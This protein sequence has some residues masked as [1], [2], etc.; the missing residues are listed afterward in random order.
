MEITP[1][2]KS[3]WAA[4]RPALVTMCKSGIPYEEVH[5]MLLTAYIDV[6]VQVNRGNISAAGRQIH[7]HRNT[8]YRYVDIK[9]TRHKHPR[10]RP[11]P[12]TPA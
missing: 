10:P 7:L 8:I 1:D 6:A 9:W 2:V 12:D 3:C 5:E 11:E 4:M